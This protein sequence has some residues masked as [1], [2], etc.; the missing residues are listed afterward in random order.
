MEI[1]NLKDIHTHPDLSPKLD[2]TFISLMQKALEG[3]VPVYF[4][5]V[6][7]V[8]CVPF[9]L[10]YR[11][12]LHHIAA[13]VIAEYAKDLNNKTFHKMLVYPRG[14]WFIVGDHYLE[15][16]STFEALP[17]YAPCW[18]LGKLDNEHV[19]DLQGPISPDDFKKIFGYD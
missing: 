15:L 9:D 18:I 12:D 2:E 1:V 5:A 11:P 10:D 3:E 17:A 8:L 16:F 6:P 4:A 19:R 7:L 14:K 13:Q